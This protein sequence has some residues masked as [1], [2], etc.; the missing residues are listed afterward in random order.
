MEQKAA[1]EGGT[2]GGGGLRVGSRKREVGSG[3]PVFA[4]QM[5]F[6]LCRHKSDANRRQS[7]V[8]ALLPPAPPTLCCLVSLCV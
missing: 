8:C 6:A 2:K 5:N 1:Q 7:S 4:H 3:L